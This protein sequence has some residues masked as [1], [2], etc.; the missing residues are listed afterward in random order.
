MEARSFDLIFYKPQSLLGR[1]FTK[2]QV[3]IS[4][5]N[6]LIE[7]SPF[8]GLHEKPIEMYLE[9]GSFSNIINSKSQRLSDKYYDIKIQG[10]WVVGAEYESRLNDFNIIKIKCGR[11]PIKQ[12]T[13]LIQNFLDHFPDKLIRV[14]SNRAWN[15]DEFNYLCSKIDLQRVQYFEE[16][17]FNIDD[18]RNCSM[19]LAIDDLYFNYK[20]DEIFLKN[21]KFIVIKPDLFADFNDLDLLINWSKL[22]NK[23]VSFSSLFNS[24]VGIQ[25]LGRM[26]CFYKLNGVHGLDTLKYF[27]NDIVTKPLF[28]SEGVLKKE[29]L[30][31]ELF[32][33]EL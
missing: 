8:P 16:P 33:N 17:F 6:Q 15:K 24:S 31:R 23:E 20:D 19:P 22:N 14:D 27:S 26:I 11:G 18:Y 10:L 32:L 12:E 25:N 3:T 2:R 4:T 28:F 5:R 29:D 21:F 7:F 1:T 9:D 13:V 30:E